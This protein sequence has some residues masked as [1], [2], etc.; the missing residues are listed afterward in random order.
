MKPEMQITHAKACIAD[1]ERAENSLETRVSAA[2]QAIRFLDKAL[3]ED[4]SVREYLA[5]KYERPLLHD[6]LV[7]YHAHALTLAKNLLS[8]MERPK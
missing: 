4:A 1:S 5:L 7:A 6:E 2:V 3:L 8:Q